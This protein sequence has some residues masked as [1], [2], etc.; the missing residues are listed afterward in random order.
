MADIH[1]S[2]LKLDTDSGVMGCSVKTAVRDP[3][4]DTFDLHTTMLL[5]PVATRSTA[6]RPVVN[7]VND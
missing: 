3:R 6:G 4:L 2:G 5:Q 7:T 1:L